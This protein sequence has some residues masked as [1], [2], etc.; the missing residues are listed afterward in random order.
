[1]NVS[2]PGCVMESRVLIF[3]SFDIDPL[4]D[5]FWPQIFFSFSNKRFEYFSPILESCHMK[6]G[7]AFIINNLIESDMSWQVC[8]VF[9]KLVCFACYDQMWAHFSDFFHWD[10]SNAWEITLFKCCLLVN[11]ALSLTTTAIVIIKILLLVIRNNLWVW[12]ILWFFLLI[13]WKLSFLNVINIF[14]SI[15]TASRIWGRN[16]SIYSIKPAWV[17]STAFWTFLARYLCCLGLS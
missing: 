9:T 8:D 6:Q 4:D 14:T 17:H 13:Q 11:A 12:N 3:L 7:I 10:V 1:M 15:S 2:F 5:F 16:W